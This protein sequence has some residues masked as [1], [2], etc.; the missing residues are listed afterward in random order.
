MAEDEY[1]NVKRKIKRKHLGKIDIDSGQVR[2]VIY[3]IGLP[4]EW[5]TV[6]QLELRRSP[7]PLDC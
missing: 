2:L 6:K 5:T 7:D 4:V 3:Q 1:L